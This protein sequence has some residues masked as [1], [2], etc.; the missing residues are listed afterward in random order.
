[1]QELHSTPE[2][3]HERCSEQT[4][5]QCK[6]RARVCPRK[7]VP[8]EADHILAPPVEGHVDVILSLK[9]GGSLLVAQAVTSEE[10]LDVPK[11]I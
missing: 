2:V 4:L 5:G 7:E 1:M 10:S 11:H 6:K 3:E 9:Q 8:E